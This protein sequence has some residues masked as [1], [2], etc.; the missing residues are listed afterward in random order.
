MMCLEMKAICRDI[1]NNIFKHFFLAVSN[2][3]ELE[4]Q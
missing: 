2:I 1:L 3:C 4:K